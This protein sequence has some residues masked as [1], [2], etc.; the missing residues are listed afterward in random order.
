VRRA[1]GDLAATDDLSAAVV[2]SL[3]SCAF[4]YAALFGSGFLLMGRTTG[5]AIAGVV[6]VV[7]G[8][9]TARSVSRLWHR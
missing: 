2:G 5:A 3:A 9:V 1:C 7:S 6:L 8:A 4:I